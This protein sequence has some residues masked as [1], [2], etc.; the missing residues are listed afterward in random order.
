MSYIVSDQTVI[1]LVNFLKKSNNLPISYDQVNAIIND[2]KKVE[3]KKQKAQ[4]ANNKSE[5]KS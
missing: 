5:K 1:F 4:K 3:D 2:F